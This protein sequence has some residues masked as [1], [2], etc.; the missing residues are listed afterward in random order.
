M[1]FVMRKNRYFKRMEW[2]G[3]CV[4]CWKEEYELEERNRGKSKLIGEL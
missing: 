2:N 3:G 1:V 4:L